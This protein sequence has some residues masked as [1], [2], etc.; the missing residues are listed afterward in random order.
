MQPIISQATDDPSGSLSAADTKL[1][2]QKVAS[3]AAT[4]ARK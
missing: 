1:L 2:Q 3:L 4:C